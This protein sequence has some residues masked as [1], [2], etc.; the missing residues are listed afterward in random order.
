MGKVEIIILA[1]TSII[2]SLN[3]LVVRRRSSELQS[4]APHASNPELSQKARK[5]S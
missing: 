5:V 3:W 1:L 2:G 4:S